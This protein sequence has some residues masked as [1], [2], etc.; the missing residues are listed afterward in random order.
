MTKLKEFWIF[1]SNKARLKFKQEQSQKT[2]IYY[3]EDLGGRD[4]HRLLNLLFRAVLV[5]F[6]TLKLRILFYKTLK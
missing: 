6:I 1:V 2:G 5:L 3:G 4:N